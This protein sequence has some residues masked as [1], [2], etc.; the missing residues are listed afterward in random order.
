M[1]RPLHIVQGYLR[2]WDIPCKIHL[3]EFLP[4]PEPT[5]YHRKV[6]DFSLYCLFHWRDWSTWP[7]IIK[8][9]DEHPFD[10]EGALIGPNWSAAVFHHEIKFINQQ[11]QTIHV[12]PA[13]H[14]IDFY[15]RPGVFLWLPFGDYKLIEITNDMVDV[16]TREFQPIFNRNGV[17]MPWQWCDGLMWHNPDKVRLECH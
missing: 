4:D 9:L 11:A 15:S 2:Q 7:A 1:P 17:H 8:P 3:G 14:G 12:E 6:G 13:G 16:W 5:V 10:F